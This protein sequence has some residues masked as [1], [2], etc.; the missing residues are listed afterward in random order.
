M[1][2]LA[3]DLEQGLSV[4]SSQA[5]DRTVTQEAVRRAVEYMAPRRARRKTMAE[6]AEQLRQWVALATNDATNDTEQAMF[7]RKT[8]RALVDMME[9][10]DLH[11]QPHVGLHF[12][13]QCL[14]KAVC[15]AMEVSAKCAKIQLKAPLRFQRFAV[16]V[17]RDNHSWFYVRFV[18]TTSMEQSINSKV[19]ES[20]STVV[21]DLKMG[22]ITPNPQTWDKFL[23]PRYVDSVYVHDQ[24]VG[25][26]Q[27]LPTL[28]EAFYN[29]FWIHSNLYGLSLDAG[30]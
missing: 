27:E 23:K 9:E 22:E 30:E 20:F 1:S 12:T 19:Q 7:I 14:Q 3:S 6:L 10:N 5:N 18:H 17:W 13:Y 28:I 11:V 8:A 24:L 29:S 26:L 16:K 15:V 4:T 21:K 25:G 2:D